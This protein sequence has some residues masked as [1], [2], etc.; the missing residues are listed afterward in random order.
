MRPAYLVLVAGAVTA[1]GQLATGT[2]PRPRILIGAGV[3]GLVIAA[4]DGPQ[5][6]VAQGLAGLIL[7]TSILTSGAAVAQGVAKA[8]TEYQPTTPPNSDP[9][10]QPGV[11]PS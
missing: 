4:I 10:Q 6:R 7:L 9:T 11:T 1:A 5:P 3:A 8:L 2:T